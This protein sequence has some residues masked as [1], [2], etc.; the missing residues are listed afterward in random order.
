M[1]S[2]TQSQTRA[3]RPIS[4]AIFSSSRNSSSHNV[5]GTLETM[6][7]PGLYPSARSSHSIAYIAVEDSIL[8]SRTT[9]F[10]WVRGELIAK[11]SY[12]SVY[13]AMNVNNGELM[14]VKQV[15]TPQ[16]PSDRADSRQIEMVE[17]LKFES[18]TLKDLDH[19]NIV[20]YLGYEATPA[21]LSIFLEYV[22]GGT[23]GSCLLKHGKFNPEVTKSFTSQILDGL[24]YLHS[25][26]IIHRDL[27]GDNILVETSGVCKITDFGI[28]KKEDVKGQAFT[29]L[30][31]T[32][33]WMAPEIVDN[34]KRGYDCKVDIW[35][36]GCVVLEMWSGERPWAGEEVISVM[37]KLYKDKSPPP[38]PADITLDDLAQDFR[39]E[40]FALNPQ[41]R[42]AAGVL[43]KH[44]YLQLT[45]GWVFHLSDIERR[46]ARVSVST[47]HEGHKGNNRH[48][49]SSAP[50]PRHRRTP[51]DVPPVPTQTQ[52]KESLLTL[53][54]PTHLRLPSVDTSPLH[55]GSSRR[56]PSRPPSTEPPPIV[57]ITPPGSP[58]RISSR[59]SMSS[60]S[61]RTS[62]SPQPRKSFYVANPDPEDEERGG[63]LRVPYVYNPPPL[64]AGEPP[65]L[66][67]TQRSSKRLKE[68]QSR[69]SVADFKARGERRLVSNPSV[70]DLT[71]RLETLSSQQS[72]SWRDD[73]YSESDSDS[74]AGTLWKKP[75]TTLRRS[76]SP[77]K[78]NRT[79][80]RRSIIETKQ[81]TTWAPR[82]GVH[83][84][85]SNLQDFFPRVDLDK[86]IGPSDQSQADR[87]RRT[88]SI[89]MVVEVNRNDLEHAR[90]HRTSTKL[91]GYKL[92]EVTN[93]GSG[94][95]QG[96]S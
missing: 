21:S 61:T 14:A 42:P 9:S 33:Y 37:L 20:Q 72:T 30:R 16:T 31:G 94:A 73:L 47:R 52:P 1:A 87:Q 55:P 12:G 50:A 6:K 56:H 64:P 91:W 41:V 81:D 35:S 22:P 7:R 68:L 53:R 88:K 93:C 95:A 77:S 45:P 8:V 19:P 66:S 70:Q 4:S 54:P 76:S 43:R 36:L 59:D 86:P 23:I 29:E 89:R 75:P 25:T 13:L 57:Y 2:C 71:T 48:R 24:E 58:V 65:H 28:S 17:A 49:N 3:V 90:L 39:R 78:S 11:G 27:K 83:D 44:P 85:Y 38:V 96:V 32:I 79:S 92:E 15:E 84:V 18:T 82:P 46:P 34:N 60:E 10:K 5:N 80:R 63:R 51:T 26:G 69:S 67:S 40:C 74:N 62:A